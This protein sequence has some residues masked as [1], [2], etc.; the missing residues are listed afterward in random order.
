MAKADNTGFELIRKKLFDD[1]EG[2][3]IILNDRQQAQMERWNYVIELRT[4]DMLHTKDI[5][6]RLM[7]NFGIERATAFNDIGNAEALFGYSTPLNKR[8]RIGARINYLEEKIGDLYEKG[9]YKAC[10]MMESTLQKYYNDYP[11]LK[12]QDRPTKFNFIY[13][14][15]K[16]PVKDLPSTE[17]AEAILMQDEN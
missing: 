4:C 6:V 15:D 17:D 5:I 7:E 2:H 11:E 12:K 3:D 9:E 13:N 8:Y 14:G 16:E 1:E 10:A